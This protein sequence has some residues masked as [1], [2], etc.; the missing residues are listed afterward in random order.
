[1]LLALAVPIGLAEP[2]HAAS[3]QVSQRT[4]VDPAGATV[5]VSG[6]GFDARRNNGFGV[7]VVFGPRPANYF[8]D[9][10]LFAAAVWVHP[11]GGGNGQARMS[12]SGSFSV[13]LRVKARYTDGNGKAVDCLAVACYVMTMAAHGVPD[14]SQDSMV[15]IAFKG[16]SRTP[17]DTPSSTPS[18][19][20]GGSNGGSGSSSL[21]TTTPAGTAGTAAPAA[22]QGSAAAGGT[23]Q[24]FAT[25][26]AAESFRQTASSAPAQSPALFWIV[27]AALA[28]AG[29]GVR[30]LARRRRRR[31][32]S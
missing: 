7:Y 1:M 23:P 28:A 20:T 17:T 13:S 21:G 31:P 10:N 5:S 18:G 11:K 4:G 19:G 30:A 22:P 12:P 2:A 14:R 27:L 29:F 15:P 25:P 9:A 26:V 6:S 3:L 32:A 8:K 24:G 16:R